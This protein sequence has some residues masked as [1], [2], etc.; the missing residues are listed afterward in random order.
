MG[1]DQLTAYAEIIRDVSEVLMLET[2]TVPPPGLIA[3]RGDQPIGR[4]T[5]R[6]PPFARSGAR[7]GGWPAATPCLR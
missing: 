2:G 7:L 5:T 4:V 3:F 1:L 6:R